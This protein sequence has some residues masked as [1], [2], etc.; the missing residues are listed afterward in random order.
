MENIFVEGGEVGECRGCQ[1]LR[2]RSERVLQSRG[3]WEKEEEGTM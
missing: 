3:E 1:I 2:G